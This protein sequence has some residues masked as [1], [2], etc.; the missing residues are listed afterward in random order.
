MFNALDVSTSALVAQRARLDVISSNLANISTTR[1]EQGQPAA[2]TPRYV[3]F[4]TDTELQTSGGGQGVKDWQHRVF[5]RPAQFEVR[6]RSP[7]CQCRRLRG[8]PQHLT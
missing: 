6:A 3:T 8:V 5:R 7:R 4:E 2:Y 1:N